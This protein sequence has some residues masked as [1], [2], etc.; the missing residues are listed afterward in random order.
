MRLWRLAL[1]FIC[2]V[3]L[4]SAVAP[5][6]GEEVIISEVP[7]YN[8][9]H[10]CSPTA[11]MMVMAYWDTYGYSALISGS[12][13][14][15]SNQST[16]RDAIASPEHVADYA[17]YDGVN[18]GGYSS[19][20]TDKSELGGAHTDNCLA[21]FMQTSFSSE[22]LTYGAT[23]ADRIG[24]G[25]QAY[26]SWRGY[27]FT[28]GGSYYSMPAWSDFT[29]EILMGR[30]VKLGVDTD[31]DGKTDH[32]VT[33]IGYRDT[34]GYWEYACRD[35]WSTSSTPR[36]ERFRAVSDTYSWGVGGWN[37]FRPAGTNRDTMWTSASGNWQD[38]GWSNGVPNPLAYACITDN[39]GI[40][41][42][43]NAKAGYVMNRGTMSIQ[44]GTFTVGTLASAGSIT[45]SGGS[46][47]VSG[48]VA[49]GV[50]GIYTISGGA[51][52]VAAELDVSGEFNLASS[53]AQVVVK[54]KLAFETGSTFTAV[55]GATIHMTG[56]AF[57]NESTNSDNLGGLGNL[58]M[59]FEGGSEDVDPFE[60]AGLDMGAVMEGLDSNFA[61]GTLQLG[62]TAAGRI[63]LVDDFDNQAD[64]SGVG[65]A[66]YVNNLIM[67]AGATIDTNGLNLYYLNGGGPKQFFYGDV[68]LNGD[69]DWLDYTTLRGNYGMTVGATWADGDLDGDGDV[70][71]LDHTTLRGNYTESC[72]GVVPEPVTLVLMAAAAPI[73]LRRKQK[74]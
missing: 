55:L 73:L 38:T 13:I 74:S 52:E 65:E 14:W 39:A 25:V 64:G 45:Q 3:L 18:D 68:D 31:G 19:P 12:N 8:W 51:L 9:T 36:W 40:T 42:S 28:A 32:S 56:S 50:N 37:S 61:L 35:T 44:R 57:K 60:A 58:T 62:G 27:S 6:G 4:A 66:V 7:A 71:W 54:D 23:W 41:I 48:T 72:G 63:Q 17:L 43:A 59:I 24:S 22:G 15:S 26:A 34:N 1:S 11:G 5:A 70:D 67:N 33:A 30:P 10:G 47:N 69:V 20:Y 2:I 21:D 53:A 46:V 16:I 29:R 49:V